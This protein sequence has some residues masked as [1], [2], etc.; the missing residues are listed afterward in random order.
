MYRCNYVN[1]LLLQNLSS[2]TFIDPQPTQTSVSSIGHSLSNTRAAFHNKITISQIHETLSCSNSNWWCRWIKLTCL[3]SFHSKILICRF[4]FYLH[5]IL[6]QLVE[7]TVLKNFINPQ[8]WTSTMFADAVV[9]I[10]LFHKLFQNRV[11]S[12]RS[13]LF[14]DDSDQ[15]SSPLMCVCVWV[16]WIHYHLN[17]IWV[18]VERIYRHTR[19][20][21]GFSVPAG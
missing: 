20:S 6:W 21:D 11:S 1:D 17:K 5:L 12:F 8:R 13:D 16:S 3:C 9:F 2:T 18:I 19:R 7:E 14:S 15:R 4:C 10:Y